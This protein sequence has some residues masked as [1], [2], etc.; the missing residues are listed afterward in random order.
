M[1][2]L[3][4]RKIGIIGYS[5]TGKAAADFVKRKGGI[6]YISDI[7]K[8]IEKELKEKGYKYELGK[9]SS[10]FLRETEL[11]I[12]SPGVKSDLPFLKELKEK[13]KKII[14]EIEFASYFI[15]GR[16]IGITGS[17][18]KSTVT[19]LIYHILKESGKKVEI[20]GNIGFPFID[21]VENDADYFVVEL[22]SFQLENIS[23]FKPYISILLNVT[24]DHLDR[25]DD[26]NEYGFAKFNIFKNQD[27]NDYAVLN[28]EDD[29]TMK[30]LDKIRALKIFF[31]I[32]KQT[33]IYGKEG[34]I[35]YKGEKIIDIKDIPLIG[36]HNIENVMAA[37]GCLKIIDI[38]NKKIEE[39]IKTFKGLEH[40]TEKCGERNGV[41]FINDSKATNIDA[42]YKALKSFKSNVILILGGKDKG[43]DFASLNKIIK[44]RVKLVILI[45]ASKEKI[46]KQLDSNIPMIEVGGMK[47]AVEKSYEN[48]ESGDVVLLSPACASFDMYD[49][50]EERGKD[51]KSLVENLIREGKNG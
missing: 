41:I 40:R 12:I 9:N 4:N 48:S 39:G 18:G 38:D 2:D 37:I 8:K 14:S 27:E 28:K 24:P 20:V 31:S 26:F 49:N 22:S 17:N 16:I 13:G 46:K 19:S 23:R 43:G 30:N 45:G 32:E 11:I 35:L 51:F 34:K 36:I 21:Y 6:V 3:R 7:N 25:Y 15:K 29:F 33:D 50:F 1:Y 47:E 5:R 42:T 44:E 10:D